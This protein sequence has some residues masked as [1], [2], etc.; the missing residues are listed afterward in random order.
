MEEVREMSAS[1][2]A[3]G[4][5]MF[6]NVR[7]SRHYVCMYVASRFRDIC[8]CICESRNSDVGSVCIYCSY[9]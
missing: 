8:I 1:G 5:R 9:S 6:E 4:R 7:F 3:G 2:A